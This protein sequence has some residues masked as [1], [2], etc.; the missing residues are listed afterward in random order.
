MINKNEYDEIFAKYFNVCKE[1][2]TKTFPNEL[3]GVL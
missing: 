1:L 3:F 2:Q